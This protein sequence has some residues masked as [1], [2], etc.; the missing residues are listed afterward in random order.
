[1][2]IQKRS[3]ARVASTVVALGFIAWGVTEA[4]RDRPTLS[5]SVNH[6]RPDQDAD[7]LADTAEAVLG[8]RTDRADTDYDGYSD[9]EEQAR[10]SDPRHPEY[11]PVPQSMRVGTCA[12]TEDGFV[13][14]TSAVYV[15]G[16]DIDNV[17]INVGV[18]H[19]GRIIEVPPSV[20]ALSRGAIIPARD[21]GDSVV[22]IEIAFP[23]C[24]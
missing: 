7:G 5:A 4:R 17:D 19:R 16:G 23:E 6:G 9:L 18:V 24:I 14:F 10:G 20:F 8:T 13:A 12:S 3:F 15:A 1:M 21:A 22:V 11:G 2:A